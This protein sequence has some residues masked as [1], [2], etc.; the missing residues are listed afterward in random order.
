MVDAVYN[1]C[2]CARIVRQ[3]HFTPGEGL[4]ADRSK[5]ESE[6]SC[7]NGGAMMA[8]VAEQGNKVVIQRTNVVLERQDENH[9]VLK[10]RKSG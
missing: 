9:F 5:S 1:S 6:P 10:K 8:V 2:M 4:T 3:W 7:S